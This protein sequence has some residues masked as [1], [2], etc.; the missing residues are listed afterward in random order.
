MDVLPCRV[1]G[2]T[3]L[4][5]KRSATLRRTFRISSSGKSTERVSL[6]LLTATFDSD[7]AAAAVGVV[8]EAASCAQTAGT[9][10]TVA[11][12]VAGT[13]NRV[14]MDYFPDLVMTIGR[15]ISSF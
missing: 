13:S 3:K 15:V 10:A 4:S 1:S 11:N 5:S 2:M 8:D 7:E 6:P 9:S 14:L 12:K